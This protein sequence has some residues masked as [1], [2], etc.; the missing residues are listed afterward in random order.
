MSSKEAIIALAQAIRETETYE[1]SDMRYEDSIRMAG[2]LYE[3]GVRPE[4]K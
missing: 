4:E 2:E 3:L 1:K